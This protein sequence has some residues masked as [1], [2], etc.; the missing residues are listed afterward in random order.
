M[1][2]VFPCALYQPR[3]LF[4]S[5]V[6]QNI[7]KTRRMHFCG[8]RRKN[9]RGHHIEYPR[10]AM[11]ICFMKLDLDWLKEDGKGAV[12]ECN[13][14]CRIAGHRRTKSSLCVTGRRSSLQFSVYLC[15]C[16]A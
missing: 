9:F 4:L 13:V 16:C 8:K 5:F 2:T 7:A 3:A 14:N 12:H 11:M 10:V 1:S 6:S 15:T